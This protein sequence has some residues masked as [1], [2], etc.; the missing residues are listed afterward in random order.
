MLVFGTVAIFVPL[1]RLEFDEKGR[2][3]FAYADEAVHSSLKTK[4]LTEEGWLNVYMRRASLH[5]RHLM[6]VGYCFLDVGKLP[7]GLSKEITVYAIACRYVYSTFG[8][9]FAHRCEIIRRGKV[10]RIVK[11]LVGE[12]AKDGVDCAL[13][14]AKFRQKMIEGRVA[15][16]FDAV[17][18]RSGV[19]E[20]IWLY[21]YVCGMIHPIVVDCEREN[22][23]LHA[24]FQQMRGF[25]GVGINSKVNAAGGVGRHLARNGKQIF[26][27]IIYALHD[28]TKTL[29]ARHLTNIFRWQRQRRNIWQNATE[30]C[31]N[32]RVGKMRHRIH[33]GT[34]VDKECVFV[35]FNHPMQNEP[36]S[37]AKRIDRAQGI[38]GEPA[39]GLQTREEV[40]IVCWE[41][42]GLFDAHSMK[43]IIKA[44][45]LLEYRRL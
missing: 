6:N 10:E 20:V 3:S 42:F 18:Y 38:I 8:K 11:K 35:A 34:C 28:E 4:S 45:I 17:G 19:D 40:G 16:G 41:S 31:R 33:K 26:T 30:D 5:K 44:T 23:E 21:D 15:I 22:I 37:P 24:L 14:L 2:L 43:G 7:L 13:A 25:K 39:H 9:E 32:R 27:F 12:V 1:A 36:G 29:A